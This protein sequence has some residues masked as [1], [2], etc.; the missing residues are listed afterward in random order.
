MAI[1][2]MLPVVGT[3]L[4][5]IPGALFLF[6]N[7][8][9]NSAIGLLVWSAVIVGNI[10]NILRPMLVGND[11]EMPDLL[12]LISTFGGLAMFGG[13]GLILG[14]V[15]AAVSFTMIEIVYEMLQAPSSDEAV[16][17]MGE[18]IVTVSSTGDDQP[19]RSEPNAPP[20]EAEHAGH[21]LLEVGLSDPQKRELDELREQFEEIKATRPSKN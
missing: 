8:E 13:T 10:D 1:A 7:G 15:I 6:A 21:G 12:V 3:S 16:E 18:P 11:T 4:V 2:S 14:P 19:A 9:T 17:P 5:W 20:D